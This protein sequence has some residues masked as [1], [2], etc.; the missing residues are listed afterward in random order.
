M[1]KNSGASERD[2]LIDPREAVGGCNYYWLFF[3]PLELL[4]IYVARM[5]SLSWDFNWWP[6]RGEH[7][8][9]MSK[10]KNQFFD[11]KII[12]E[13]KIKRFK[14]KFAAKLVSCDI[15]TSSF[16]HEISFRKQEEWSK[17]M[18]KSE[19]E[20]KNRGRIRIF[21]FR[22]SLINNQNL[23]SLKNPPSIEFNTSIFGVRV[24]LPILHSNK[25]PEKSKK[26]KFLKT[27][28][29]AI[30]FVWDFAVRWLDWG[31]EGRGG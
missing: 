27:L 10:N 13:K 26:H 9:H 22:L 5:V 6:G 7:V 23:V 28:F 21:F 25:Y 30:N 12:C 4:G 20:S 8:W 1:I 3:F 31:L 24:R 29:S 16:P 18:S 14:W 11:W 15:L 19:D 17:A 2:R